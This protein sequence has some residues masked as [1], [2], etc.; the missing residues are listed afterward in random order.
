M[1]AHPLLAYS[2]ASPS[3]GVVVVFVVF[4]VVVIGL[5]AVWEVVKGPPN[6]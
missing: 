1:T 5:N 4:L 6:P 2:A 3:L